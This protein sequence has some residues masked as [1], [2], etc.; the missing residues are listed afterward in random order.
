MSSQHDL[1]FSPEHQQTYTELCNTLYERELA[2]LAL[3]PARPVANLT[4]TLTK[5]AILRA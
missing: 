2:R 1:W 5:L 4:K 3:T